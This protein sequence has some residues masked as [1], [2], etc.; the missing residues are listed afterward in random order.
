M[1]IDALNIKMN[2]DIENKDRSNILPVF[3]THHETK[4]F[5]NK[6]ARFYDL[7]ANHSEA[8]IRKQAVEMLAPLAG[9]KILEIGFGT[10]HGLVK[11]ARSVG[12]EGKVYGVDFSEE[13]V[14]I[15]Q[16]RLEKESLRQRSILLCSDAANLPFADRTINAVFM[17]FTLELFD[18]PEIPVVLTECYRVL[19]PEGRIVVAGLS[20]IGK[21]NAIKKAYEWTHRHF[22]NILN[23]RPIFVSKALKEAGFIIKSSKIVSMWMPVEIVLTVKQ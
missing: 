1:K 14:K 17:S 22:P 10:G 8:P 3:Q 15:A 23:C 6:I 2:T 9:E 21:Q 5:Y 19:H 4:A 11:L 13:M 12:N 16:K 20:K 18:T 7:L